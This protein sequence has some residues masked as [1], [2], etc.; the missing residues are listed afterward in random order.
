MRFNLVGRME[1]GPGAVHLKVFNGGVP[2]V[3]SPGGRSVSCLGAAV[4]GG[5]VE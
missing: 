1:G 3:G 4:G 5:P 2:C